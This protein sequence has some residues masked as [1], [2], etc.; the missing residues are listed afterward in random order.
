MEQNSIHWWSSTAWTFDGLM[1]EAEF[2][3]STWTLGSDSDCFNT[4]KKCAFTCCLNNHQQLNAI[5]HY[6]LLHGLMIQFSRTAFFFSPYSFPDWISGK[7]VITV[8]KRLLKLVLVFWLKSSFKLKGNASSYN[9]IVTIIMLIPSV[10]VCACA[11]LSV[12]AYLHMLCKGAG[13]VFPPCG[14]QW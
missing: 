8:N 12:C 2:S 9:V 4:L 14:H 10:C 13:D 3:E 6:S 5:N 11:R 7:F 1:W